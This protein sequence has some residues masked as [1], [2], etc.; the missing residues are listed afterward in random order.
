MLTVKEL[1]GLAAR[2]AEPYFCRQ[3]GPFALV[4]KPPRPVVEQMALRMGAA[5]TVLANGVGSLEALQASMLL[6]FDA[7]LVATL[8]PLRT[9]DTL[10]VGRMP[11][12]DLIINDPS[13]SKQHAVLR[14]HGPTSTCC[15]T[16]LQSTNGTSLNLQPLAAMQEHVVRD[17]DILSFGD[18]DFAFFVARSLWGRL[19]GRGQVRVTA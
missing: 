17:G 13:V 11:S 14:W 1:K 19:T 6:N 12:S 9:H 15:V 16:D 10:S 3:V 2:L 4:Q 7:L 18:A 8:P 5:R